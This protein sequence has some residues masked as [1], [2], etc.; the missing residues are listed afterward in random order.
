MLS[1]RLSIQISASMSSDGFRSLT[2]VKQKCAV[3]LLNVLHCLAFSDIDRCAPEFYKIENM[4]HIKQR[5]VCS[6]VD[7][8]FAIVIVMTNGET[9]HCNV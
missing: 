8:G 9:L 1:L 7:W 2:A 3:W 4:L 6:C 5:A